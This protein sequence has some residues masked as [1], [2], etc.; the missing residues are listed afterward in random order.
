MDNS[1]GATP[2]ESRQAGGVP[3]SLPRRSPPLAT[4]GTSASSWGA[5]R[6]A[7]RLN[8]TGQKSKKRV[9]KTE[10][11]RQ[12]LRILQWNAE[13]ITRKKRALSARLHAEKIDVACIQETHLSPPN[14]K[15]RPSHPHKNISIR[16]YQ[17]FNTPR[18]GRTK[19]GVLIYVRETIQATPINVDTGQ[20][21]EI[22][23][24]LVR[25]DG[26]DIRIFNYYC[27][28]DKNLSLY[29]MDLSCD[30]HIVLG[31]FNSH[32]PSWGYSDLN[33]RGEEVEDWQITLGLHLINDADDPPTY[34]SRAWRTTSTPDLAFTS[35]EL[36]PLVKRNVQEQLAGSDHRPILLTLDLNAPSPQ[37][38]TT[39]RWNYK[40]ADWDKFAIL[41]D[42]YTSSI[43][44]KS[45]KV[46]KSSDQFVKAVL[47]AAQEAIPRGARK[48][49]KPYWN[50]TLQELH[51]EV[52]KA[53]DAVEINPTIENNVI[54]KAKTAKL[55][56]ETTASIR[57][58]WHEKTSNL[59]LDRDG[60]KLWSLVRNLNSEDDRF[61]PITLEENG[62]MLTEQETR[63]A[64][65]KQFQSVSNKDIDKPRNADVREETE[66]LKQWA[67]EPEEDIMSRPILKEELEQ[68]MQEMVTKKA[69]GPDMI[70]SDMLLHLGQKAKKKLLQ[71]YNASWK[72]SI[73]P[74]A[75]R[76]AILVPIHKKGKPKHQAGS[77]R[78]I[79]LTS[80]ICKLFERII[81]SR[82]TWF[83]E[84]NNKFC[85]EQAGFRACRSTEDQVTYISQLI[86]DG[87]QEKKQT[88]VVWVD[89]EKAFDRVWHKGLLLK[90][91]RNGVS[92]KMY[93]WIAQYL[94]NRKAKVSLRGKLSRAASFTQG[95]PQGGVLSPTL[96]LVFV[97]DITNI[98]PSN[99][100]AV[101]YADDLALVCS[102]ESLAIAQKRLQT[103]LDRLGQWSEEW[104]MR[105]NAE[106]TT[107]TIFSL[108]TKSQAINLRINDKKLREEQNP[109]YLGVTFD[110]RLTWKQQTDKVQE[111]GLHRT[112]ILKKLAGTD[113]GADA[114]ILKKT[115]TGYV[116]PIL[117]YGIAA[118]GTAAQS[119]FGKA[120]KVQNQNLR[121]ITGCM[122]STPIN[123]ME[124]VSGLQ[125]ME[126]R[127]NKK[128]LTQY[129]K[130]Q[131]LK[132]HPMNG[133]TKKKNTCR[134]KRT[135]FLTK[136]RDLHRNLKIP[137]IDQDTPLPTTSES[138]PWHNRNPPEIRDMVPGITNKEELT[139]KK[140]KELT[141][142]H[143][144]QE[145]P[146][147]DWIRVYTDGSAEEAVRNG[148]GGIVIE[149]TDTTT[150]ERSI[151]TGKHSSNYKAEAAALEEAAV[152]IQNN[153]CFG[154]KVVFLTDAKS[155]LQAL[156]NHKNKEHNSLKATLQQ[157]G[158]AAKQIVMQWIPGHCNVAGNDRA[159]MLAKEGSALEQL[160]DESTYEES[161]SHIKA[162]IQAQWKKSHPSYN[163]G[164]PILTLTRRH[165]TVIMR[166]RTG[167]N[168]LRQ[169]M[170]KKFKIGDTDM[171]P[172][173]LAPQDSKHILQ[174][175][176]QMDEL[177]R[178][179]WPEETSLGEKLYGTADALLTTAA[180]V[181]STG[182]QL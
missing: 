96:F 173:G 118:W 79:S 127:K 6:R 178:G 116:R 30:H 34:Y 82:L 3:D 124:S 180:F 53:R 129:S 102:E 56:K 157:L 123:A 10:P 2:V 4:G 66:K 126:D 181:E 162:A 109:T 151:P 20:E 75:W 76:K 42:K 70:T 111:K 171:C 83:F 136:A 154:K 161:K 31:D 112:A 19:G 130:F 168:R 13:G 25:V 36:A 140:L 149:W 125:S 84:K 24:V 135:N 100:R 78:P 89:F 62:Q 179:Y 71:I 74:Q 132:N 108:S 58:S 138:P 44:S 97:N 27:P 48:D 21:A 8:A 93:K 38:S 165:Q 144:E 61:T 67:E 63:N 148:G 46:N 159:D 29:N 16:G 26:K 14:E 142:R 175:C 88:A 50:D 98:L 137:P 107:C 167:H 69:P 101:M 113:W 105:V 163:P 11:P 177:R 114:N 90:L 91:L 110:Q 152:I 45:K 85:D 57:K 94:H 23:G 15:T 52:S 121:L 182:L 143:V 156:K 170:F 145:Y 117:E 12:P 174:D 86:E 92:H 158:E 95:V 164:D 77:Y 122:R 103:T 104:R 147:E 120:S 51:D 59:K 40:K 37:H 60:S 33:Q 1:C 172:C 17:T 80:C 18:E 169:H 134:L 115:Y 7:R 133:R 128:I 32:S 176:P 28:P 55:K 47:K 155:V 73:V 64:L 146:K 72:Y 65:L 87:F 81:N 141:I 131:T 119:N 150:T 68:A 22:V 99:V 160:E 54:L 9:P 49:Y 106:K 139:A 35:G 166:L 43:V 41:A 5:R 153:N 39:P